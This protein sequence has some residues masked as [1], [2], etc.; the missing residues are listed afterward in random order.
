MTVFL[1]LGGLG[2]LLL[3]ATLLLDDHIDGLTDALGGGDWFTGMAVAG[4]LGALGFVGALV[5]SLTQSDVLGWVCG[6]VAGVALGVVVGWVTARL[7]GSGAGSVPSADQLVGIT[8]VVATPIP[9]DG[10]GSVRLR[11]GGHLTTMNAR[12]DVPIAT[13][14]TVWVVESISPSAVLVRPTHP[15]EQG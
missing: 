6:I 10:F 13:G 1:V 12:C 5:L 15:D 2:V 14:E 3:M 7:R 8:A 9:A 4:F 11:H